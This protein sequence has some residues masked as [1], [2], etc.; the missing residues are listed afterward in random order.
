MINLSPEKATS[1]FVFITSK[2]PLPK[3]I[4]PKMTFKEKEG[5]TYIIKKKE[6]QDY[7]FAF[8]QT[9]S[10]ISLAYESDLEMTGLTAAISSA[11]GGAKI[12]CNIVAAFYHDH[13]FVPE[14]L[15]EIAMSIL[16]E[17]E[18]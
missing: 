16:Q 15:S 13:I 17:I 18:I 1:S 11:L 10:L 5:H 6:A 12:P 9:W 4:N 8:Q 3:E 2:D 7:N 14:H